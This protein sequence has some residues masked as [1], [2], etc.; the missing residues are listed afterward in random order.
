MNSTRRI[1]WAAPILIYAA[2]ALEMIIMVTPFAAYFYSVYTPL[3]HGLEQ[4]ALTA[5]LPQFFLPH[6]AHTRWPFFRALSLVGAALTLIGLLGFLA[7]AIQLYYGKFVKKRLVS[8]GLYGRVRHPQYLCLVIAGAGLL[9]L[10]PRFFIL[11]TYLMMLGLYYVLAR[12]EE[13]AIRARYGAPADAYLA[14]VPMFNPFGRRQPSARFAPPSRGKAFMAWVGIC[15]VALGLAF[16]LRALALTQL[17]LVRIATPPV[18]ALSFRVRSAE[19]INGIMRNV[20]NNQSVREHVLRRPGESLF[21]QITAGRG[22]LKHLL[23]DLGMVSAA[24]EALPLPEQGEFVVLSRVHSRN[25][26][27]PPPADPFA[28]SSQIEPL[29]LAMPDAGGMAVI[30]LDPAQFHPG[31]VRIRF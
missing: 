3:F 14:S 24:I 7:C 9:L 18:T 15:V 20:L 6:L 12:H 21:M 1:A 25:G 13:E 19:H 31:F 5:W 10:W 30:A 22:Q 4:N 11:I 29:F 8:G 23:I 17:Y 26:A 16:G 28:F 2:S 27:G